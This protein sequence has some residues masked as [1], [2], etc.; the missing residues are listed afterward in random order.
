MAKTAVASFGDDD[1]KRFL[2][3]ASTVGGAA[4]MLAHP[5]KEAKALGAFFTL[6]GLI[7]LFM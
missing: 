4:A 1:F 2:G 3:V 7:A 5:K 6:L